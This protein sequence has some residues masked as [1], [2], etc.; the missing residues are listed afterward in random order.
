MKQD[1]DIIAPPKMSAISYMR[2]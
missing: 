2:W 1:S